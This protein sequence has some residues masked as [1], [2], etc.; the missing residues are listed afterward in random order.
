LLKTIAHSAHSTIYAS[1]LQRSAKWYYQAFGFQ[2][3]T[4]NSDFAFIEI[5][6]GR[7]LEMGRFAGKPRKFGFVSKNISAM[8]RQLA[9][10][11]VEIISDEGS[12][13]NVMDPDG[14]LI[15]I[16]SSGYG[17]EF[18]HA[19]FPEQRF[20]DTFRC[21]I[22][23][24]DEMR[25]IACK[26]TDDSEFDQASE[27]LISV[28]NRQGI[29]TIG[30][31]FIASECRHTAPSIPGEARPMQVEN[32]YACVSIA[33]TSN[34][35]LPERMEHIVIPPFDYSVFPIEYR[36][37]DVL[38]TNIF[39]WRS[40]FM[41][42]SFTRPGGNYFILEQYKDD[43]IHISIPYFWDKGWHEHNKLEEERRR[44]EEEANVEKSG[45]G[46][47]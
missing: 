15:E 7:V 45:V 5:A 47:N 35:E 10:A 30:E 27:K 34:I 3:L 18:L 11:N 29:S 28:C 31:T 20:R 42:L 38:R 43:Y 9:K 41:A 44:K 39:E 4:I 1:D 33:D 46:Q 17:V 40:N 25:L 14:N 36:H 37:I 21:R 19:S 16:R 32:I 13:L 6:L 23:T 26:I 12:C 2:I 22:E 8:K 24:R